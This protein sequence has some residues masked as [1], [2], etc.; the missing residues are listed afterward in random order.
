MSLRRVGF[1]TFAAALFVGTVLL[2]LD[3]VLATTEAFCPGQRSLSEYVLQGVQVWP[4][5][6]FYSNGCNARTLDPT[7]ALAYL[8]ALFGLVVAAAGH[9]RASLGTE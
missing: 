1:T 7:F 6:V 2:V 8:L 4:P 3:P 5:R 9:V